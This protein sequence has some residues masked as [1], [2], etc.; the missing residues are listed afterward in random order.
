MLN[1]VQSVVSKALA[2]KE[3]GNENMGRSRVRLFFG[4]KFDRFTESLLL[5]CHGLL[6][7]AIFTFINENQK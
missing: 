2:I 4:P 5:L 1:F 3:T 7:F 6:Y